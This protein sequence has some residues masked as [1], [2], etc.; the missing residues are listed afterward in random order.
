[1]CKKLNIVQVEGV[2]KG[3]HSFRRNNITDVVNATNGNV[4]MASTLFGNT[5]D[6][7]EKNYYTGANLAVAKQALESR[8]FLTNF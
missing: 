7:A 6:V 2:I 3:T 8:N 4:I 1:M 5:P